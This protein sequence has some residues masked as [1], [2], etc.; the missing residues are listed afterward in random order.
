MFC[1]LRGSKAT[2]L[3]SK[4]RRGG[5]LGDAGRTVSL[6]VKNL[7]LV[8]KLGEEIDRNKVEAVMHDREGERF[9]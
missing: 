4:G 5:E 9:I 6:G 3:P 1:N 7:I 2:F 8:T